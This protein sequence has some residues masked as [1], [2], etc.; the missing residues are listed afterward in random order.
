MASDEQRN[1]RYCIDMFLVS[2][3]LQERR[4]TGDE[5]AKEFSAIQKVT[6]ELIK[7]AL[8]QVARVYHS[9]CMGSPVVPTAH[10]WGDKAAKS[11]EMT[12]SIE[13]VIEGLW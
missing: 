5:I 4:P 1:L 11:K 3:I 10:D 12:A 9:L 2:A 8:D 7:I 13:A 6:G